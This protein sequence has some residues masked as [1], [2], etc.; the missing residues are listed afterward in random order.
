MSQE[1]GQPMNRFDVIDCSNSLITVSTLVTAMNCFHKYNS[2]FPT[3]SIGLTWYRN[4]M[5]GVKI[6]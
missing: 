1:C 5:R 2:K 6:R 4:F 3:R